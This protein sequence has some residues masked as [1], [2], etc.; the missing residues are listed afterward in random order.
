MNQ[1]V[2]NKLNLAVDWIKVTKVAIGAG[3][4]KYF[5]QAI[6]TYLFGLYLCTVLAN[7]NMASVRNGRSNLSP[8]KA[9]SLVLSNG[10]VVILFR[11]YLGQ[12]VCMCNLELPGEEYS[13]KSAL[14]C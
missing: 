12:Y 13:Y 1:F 14:F 6:N 4:L 2:D 10:S 9:L 7:K 5:T 3:I 11:K 8:H